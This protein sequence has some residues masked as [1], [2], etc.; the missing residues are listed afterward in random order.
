MNSLKIQL[1][2][3]ANL[4]QEALERFL[5]DNGNEDTVTSAMRYSLLGGSKRH[6]YDLAL[7]AILLLGNRLH[8]WLETDC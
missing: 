8:C 1:E 7:P 6:Q 3:Y 5:P 2:A 4:T